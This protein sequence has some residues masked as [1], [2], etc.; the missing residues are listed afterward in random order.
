M[1]Q[2]FVK[3]NTF[4]VSKSVF[5]SPSST[6]SNEASTRVV[7]DLRL[8]S[9]RLAHRKSHSLRSAGLVASSA[10]VISS[11]TTPAT[12]SSQPNSIFLSHHSSFSLPNAV[13]DQWVGP[14]FISTYGADRF[15]RYP[16]FLLAVRAVNHPSWF[17]C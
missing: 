2:Q 13:L 10:T 12:S 9:G 14:L 8:R 16:R 3:K 4:K 11:H 15:Q 1:E 17:T 7:I 5:F 6:R